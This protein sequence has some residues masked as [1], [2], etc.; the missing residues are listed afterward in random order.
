MSRSTIIE[1]CDNGMVK[2]AVIKKRGAQRGIRLIYMPS[3]HAALEKL[4]DKPTRSQQSVA[5]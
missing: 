4:A 5:L 1:M 3:L 2:N